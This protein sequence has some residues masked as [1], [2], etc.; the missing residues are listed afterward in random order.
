[1]NKMNKILFIIILMIFSSNLVSIPQQRKT[2]YFTLK[3]EFKKVYPLKKKGYFY[4]ENLAGEV[5]INSWDKEE[6]E[7]RAL[8]R[9]RGYDDI[10]VE[11][12]YSYDEVNISTFYPSSGSNSYSVYY[13]V[14]IPRET[15]VDLECMSSTIIAKNIKGSSELRTMSGDVILDDSEGRF[16]LK[17]MSG[18][19]E[20]RNFKGEMEGKNASGDIKIRRSSFSFF[21]LESMSGDVGIK[22]ESLDMNGRFRAETISGNI[23]LYLKEDVKASLY[24]S[25]PKKN[26]DSEF[27][28]FSR[29]EERDR[30]KE[31]IIRKKKDDIFDIDININLNMDFLPSKIEGII[32]GGGARISLSTTS[33][34]VDIRKF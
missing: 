6:V 31:I 17:T 14:T 19:I 32:N 23:L 21:D 7:I 3:D 18:E 25:A 13:D 29:F 26:F 4:L 27:E 12:T 30:K 15:N 28:I 22:A 20:V 34:K 11:I 24:I 33:G 1:M 5:R 8:V 9:G 16:Y 10:E 2:E